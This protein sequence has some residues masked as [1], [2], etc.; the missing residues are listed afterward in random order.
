LTVL[1]RLSKNLPML[2]HW[3]WAAKFI[4]LLEPVALALRPG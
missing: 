2:S 4:A 1:V 3:L